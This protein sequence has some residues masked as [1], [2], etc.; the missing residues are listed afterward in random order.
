VIYKI[1]ADI[2]VLIHFLWIIFLITGGFLGRRNRIIKF[3]HLGGLFFAFIIQIFEWYC[4]L[5]HLETWLREKHDPSLSYSGSFIIHYLEKLIY[6]ELSSWII[7]IL[8][9]LLIIFNVFLYL[10]R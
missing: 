8:T 1:F 3:F 2:V 5:T 6:I 9:V 7:F 4:P 10:R